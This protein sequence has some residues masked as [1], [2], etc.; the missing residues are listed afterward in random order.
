MA[1]FCT[2]GIAERTICAKRTQGI[3][4][5]RGEIALPECMLQ[6]RKLIKA[7]GDSL[8]AVGNQHKGT[9]YGKVLEG[10][11]GSLGQWHV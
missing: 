6:P 5:A 10:L 11:P 2:S 7:D 9:V 4:Q 1:E 8:A 3:T